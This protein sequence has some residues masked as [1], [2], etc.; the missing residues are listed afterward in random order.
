LER[1]IR[2]NTDKNDT[3]IDPFMGSG[4]TGA[5]CKKQNRNFIGIELTEY[6]YGQAQKY[7]MGTL[8][9]LF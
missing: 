4:T 1:I 3:I 2:N 7:I 9:K 5:A 8:N 6:Y